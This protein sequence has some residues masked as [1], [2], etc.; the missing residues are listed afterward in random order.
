M[1]LAMKE[2]EKAQKRA[3]GSASA[4]SSRPP[5]AMNTPTKKRS[6]PAAKKSGSSTPAGGMDQ[7]HFDLSALNLTRDDG[8][9][10]TIEEPPKMNFAR[11]R[12]LEEAKLVIDAEGRNKKKGVSL[13]VI[14]M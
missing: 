6:G 1:I 7:R 4:S 2:R 14:G 13:V 11:E 3:M 5:S 9:N 8:G 10:N 12:L